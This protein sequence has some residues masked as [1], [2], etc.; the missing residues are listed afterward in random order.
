MLFCCLKEIHRLSCKK[1]SSQPA[2]LFSFYQKFCVKTR[3]F[4]KQKL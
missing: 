2:T 3:G 4:E 1:K